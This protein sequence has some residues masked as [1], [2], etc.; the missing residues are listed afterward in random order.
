MGWDRNTQMGIEFQ[1][2]RAGGGSSHGARAWPSAGAKGLEVR[3]QTIRTRK[4]RVQ[5]AAILRYMSGF[6]Y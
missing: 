6:L 2:G 5:F 4:K 3:G 1:G